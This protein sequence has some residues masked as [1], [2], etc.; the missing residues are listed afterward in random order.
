MGISVRSDDIAYHFLISLRIPCLQDWIHT[1]S[2][3]LYPRPRIDVHPLL[4]G[5]FA[6][7]ASL[8]RRLI[9]NFVDLH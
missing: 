1:G 7:K 6:G 4:N 8:P 5:L 3:V 9:S 2:A